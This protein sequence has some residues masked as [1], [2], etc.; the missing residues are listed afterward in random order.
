MVPSLMILTGFLADN[1]RDRLGRVYFTEKHSMNQ[2]RQHGFWHRAEA[3]GSY[4]QT[5]AQMPMHRAVCRQPI[6]QHAVSHIENQVIFP[7]TIIHQVP[8]GQH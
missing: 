8:L 2:E 6:L 1:G 5:S 3:G 4:W 7:K